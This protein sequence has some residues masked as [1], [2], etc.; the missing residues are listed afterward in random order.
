M[1]PMRTATLHLKILNG[2]GL[3]DGGLDRKDM[4]SIFTGLSVNVTP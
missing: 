2:F 3:L 4:G 1:T